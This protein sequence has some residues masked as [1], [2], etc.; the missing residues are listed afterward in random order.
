[1]ACFNDIKIQ[2]TDLL[3]ITLNVARLANHFLYDPFFV[4]PPW[5]IVKT[6]LDRNFKIKRTSFIHLKIMSK[7]PLSVRLYRSD[8]V[9]SSNRLSSSKTT[10][11]FSRICIIFSLLYFAIRVPIFPVSVGLCR[12][13]IVYTQSRGY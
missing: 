12:H 3:R 5:K 11:I 10:L 4:I 7:S 2:N 13:S 9:A 6:L 1:M 8:K